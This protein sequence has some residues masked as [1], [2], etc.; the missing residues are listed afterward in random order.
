MSSDST[1]VTE[2]DANPGQVIIERNTQVRVE[3]GEGRGK[4]KKQE[5]KDFRVLALF[6]KTYNKWFLCDEG[7]QSWKDKMGKGKFR[8]LM[9]MVEFDH[10]LGKYYD[11]KPSSSMKWGKKSIYV[12]CDASAIKSVIRQL[13][14]AE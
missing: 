2:D 9:R 1:P 6:T 4:K 5:V 11:V 8:V 10:S 3:V 12:L 14:D 13:G 7:K